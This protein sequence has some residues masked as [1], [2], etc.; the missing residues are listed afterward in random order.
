MNIR[1]EMHRAIDE[2]EEDRLLL[3]YRVIR[4]FSPEPLELPVPPNPPTIEKV[5][6]LTAMDKSDWS[7]QLIEEREDRV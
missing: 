1:E 4:D 2:M 6:S 5:L 7:Q 3:A